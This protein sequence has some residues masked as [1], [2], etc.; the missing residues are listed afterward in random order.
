MEKEFFEDCAVAVMRVPSA[1][2]G[3]PQR[4]LDDVQEIPNEEEELVIST[5]NCEPEN[6]AVEESEQVAPGLVLEFSTLMPM[7]EAVRLQMTE[8]MGP[9]A[10]DGTIYGAREDEMETEDAPEVSAPKPEIESARTELPSAY[11]YL[12]LL[13]RVDSH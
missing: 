4:I 3:L 12:S 7:D 9:L 10:V 1:A 6:G 8:P 13:L 11:P 5:V 2:N